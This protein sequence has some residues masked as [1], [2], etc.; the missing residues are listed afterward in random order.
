MPGKF[1]Q[2]LDINITE[3]GVYKLLYNLNP[4]KAAGPDKIIPIVLK[5]L[6][7]HIAPILTIIF[8]C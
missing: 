4:N 6:A 8:S 1:E 3:N 7:V 2:I 5:E